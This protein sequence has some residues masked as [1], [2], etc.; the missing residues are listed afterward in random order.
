M[1]LFKR[2]IASVM[3]NKSK[4]A[5]LF[6]I[7]LVL[8]SLMAGTLLT[9]RASVQAQQ[10]AINNMRP[11]AI[12]GRDW[13]S[14]TWAAATDD[15]YFANRPIV[16]P[17]AVELVYEISSLPYVKRYS[18]FLEQ[19]LFSELKIYHP[20]ADEDDVF[21]FDIRTE[22]GDMFYLRGVQE[23]NFADMELGVIEITSGRTFTEEELESASPVIIISESLAREN[24]L[25][26]GSVISFRKS[27]FNPRQVTYF[28]CFREENTLSSLF[29]EVEVIGTYS[30]AID[31]TSPFV[32]ADFNRW[33]LEGIY[34]RIYIPSGFMMHITEETKGLATATGFYDMIAEMKAI[35]TQELSWE[36]GLFMYRGLYEAL[37]LYYMRIE[38]FFELHHPNDMI[39]FMEAV[40]PLLPEYYIVHFSDNNFVEMLIAFESL[41]SISAI[42]FYIMIGAMILIF[43]LLVTLLVRTRRNE[44]GILLAVGVRKTSIALQ[45][46]LEI[47]LLTVPALIIALIIGSILGGRISE[48]MLINDL[49]I[50]GE[51]SQHLA[52][53]DLFFW[54][55]LGGEQVAVD[56]LL[57]NYD[58][59]LTIGLSVM[60]FTVV[61]AIILITSTIS[62]CYTLQIKSKEILMF[63]R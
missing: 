51:T 2:S 41:G 10:N 19:K 17:L 39:P 12:V 25:G 29:F 27:L 34:N 45:M 20:Q 56:T 61:I 37:D 33:I 54:F 36:E 55:G 47:F 9:N 60:F 59:A 24:Q 32:D 30:I 23:T 15:R 43:Y 28:G 42:L 13:F 7:V 16:P 46:A 8:G 63:I 48:N 11:Q 58:N 26:I 5:L 22:L 21:I 1:N 57:N 38:T 44:I 53:F 52:D 35:D 18:Y 62:L 14:I 6:L 40:E 4:S 3:R 31:T 50:I 49:L